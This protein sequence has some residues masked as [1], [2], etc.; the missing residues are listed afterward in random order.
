MYGYESLSFCSPFDSSKLIFEL[1]N[2]VFFFEFVLVVE[3]KTWSFK[4]ES[5]YF[6]IEVVEIMI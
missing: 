6:D 3:S 2:L 5:S 4:N 1:E